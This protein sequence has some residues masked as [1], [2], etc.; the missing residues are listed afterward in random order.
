MSA[1][2]HR[3]KAADEAVRGRAHQR[4]YDAWSKGSYEGAQSRDP[5][6]L[7]PYSPAGVYRRL[8]GDQQQRARQ[9]L[10]A[11]RILGE[12]EEAECG[13]FPPEIRVVCPLI[14]QVDAV[15]N[16]SNGVRVRLADGIDVAAAI[17]H[18]R[19]HLAFARS[20][21]HVGMDECP[22]YLRGVHVERVARSHSIDLVPA[23]LDDLEALRLRT[24]RHVGE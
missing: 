2:A 20:H 15:E 11:A 22:L 9:H 13:A 21:G 16:I 18:M 14:G 4:R 8:A 19:C 10:E 7:E 1:E 17:T 3:Q 5:D 12:F 23:N 6:Q 24:S